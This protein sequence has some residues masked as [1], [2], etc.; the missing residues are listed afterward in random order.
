MG[1][2]LK[3]T[4]RVTALAASLGLAAGCATTGELEE[5]RTI[6]NNALS[7]ANQAR[8]TASAAQSTASEAASAAAQAQ[9][10]ADAAQACCNENA[11]K[12]ERAF[13]MHMR[14]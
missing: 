13:E 12:I 9:Q 3:L 14:K 11:D 8:D 1:N 5:V 7:T 10:S 6:A 2:R 4:V